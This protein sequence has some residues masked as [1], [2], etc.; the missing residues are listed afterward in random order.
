MIDKDIKEKKFDCVI[1]KGY[2]I[3]NAIKM[4]L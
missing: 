3:D 4:G 1:Y 2:L